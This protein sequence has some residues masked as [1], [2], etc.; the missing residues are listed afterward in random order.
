[1]KKLLSTLCVFLTWIN[2][3]YANITLP[4]FSGSQD[5]PSLQGY[6]NSLV[7]N[8]NN[9]INNNILPY[10]QTPTY[11]VIYNATSFSAASLAS[12]TANGVTPTVVGNALQ[13]TGGAGTFTQSYDYSA[14]ASG[15]TM[16]DKWCMN[17]VVT[18]GTI[19]S[20]SYG[21]GIGT[22]SY[23]S[24]SNYYNAAASVNF[25]TASPGALYIYA[26]GSNVA[27]SANNLSISTG[28][29]VSIT[30]CRDENIVTANAYDVTTQSAPVTISYAYTMKP[31]TAHVAPNT[32]RFAL[33]NLGGTQ[34]L[35]SLSITSREAENATIAFVGDSKTAGYYAGDQSFSFANMSKPYFNIINLSGGS[36]TTADL[37]RH[38]PEI[39]ALRPKMVVL[40]IGCNDIRYSVPLATIEANYASIV[41]QLSSAGITVYN[42]LPLLENSGINQ[43]PLKAWIQA[44]YPASFIDSGGDAFASNPTVVVASDNIHPNGYFHWLIFSAIYNYLTSLGVT[45]A[46]NDNSPANSPGVVA[47]QIPALSG[48]CAATVQLP[49]APK[50][51]VWVDYVNT[52]SPCS[53]QTIIINFQPITA[54]YMWYCDATDLT[55]PADTFHQTAFTSA[56]ATLTGTAASGDAVGIKCFAN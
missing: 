53:S 23:N 24:A 31:T 4:T 1:M 3:C 44:T 19:A 12:F 34:T 30:L 11:G 37:L 25:S 32:G 17:E 54:T 42:L 9:I 48:T 22:R 27:T 56:S 52:T 55:T 43:A 33:Y 38:V 28:D 47:N 40:E 51:G 2:L 46:V 45:A 14:G 16:L 5:V 49:T 21:L 7:N 6:L 36:D 29:S 50:N 35:T 13:F 26:N 8:L 41:S 18:V 20:G 39:V 15:N 10:L